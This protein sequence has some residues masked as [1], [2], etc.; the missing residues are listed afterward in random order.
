MTIRAVF[1]D[2]GGVIQRTEYQAPRQYLAERFGMDYDD[3]DKLVFGGGPQG[4]A[5]KATLG[6][7]SESEHWKAV[8]RRLKIQGDELAKVKAEFFA[9][10]AIDRE[11]VHFIRSLRGRFHVG[12][13]SNAWDAM[14]PHLER[15]DLLDLFD[16]LI[17]SAEVGVAKPDARIYHLALEQAKVKAVE[18]VFVDDMPENI[19][20]CQQVGMKGIL[21]KDPQEAMSRLK[22]LLGL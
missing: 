9:G 11:L 16:T 20:A 2:F 17:I 4:T 10:D 7:I 5:A 14:R 19:E 15:E 12:L 3:I 6:A 21:Y 1:F 8:A 22:Q 18:A 13:I